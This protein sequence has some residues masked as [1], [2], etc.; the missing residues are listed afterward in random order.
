MASGIENRRQ[1][2]HL[3]EV[4]LGAQASEVVG[5][6]LYAKL[7]RFGGEATPGA[8]LTLERRAGGFILRMGEPTEHR[9]IE[10]TVGTGAAYGPTDP[11]VQRAA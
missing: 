7:M 5:P 6:E 10:R 8:W 3:V 1:C 11:G 2:P 4:C 9:R